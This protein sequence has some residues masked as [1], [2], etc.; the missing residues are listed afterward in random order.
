MHNTE[1]RINNINA[2]SQVS[3]T[4]AKLAR[5]KEDNIQQNTPPSFPPVPPDKPLIHR[6]LTEVCNKQAENVISERGCAVCGHLTPANNLSKLKNIKKF[7]HILDVRGVTRKERRSEAEPI[8]EISGPVL[9]YT[10]S[11]VCQVC[12][13]S[14]YKNKIPKLALA[15]GFWLGNVP[16]EL[17]EL[18]YVEKL[19]VARIRHTA[20][21]IKI[22]TGGRKMKAHATAFEIPTPKIYNLQDNVVLQ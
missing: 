16:K 14:L 8:T 13:K 11:E 2:T 9:D 18:R 19:L 22:S 15:K 3:T 5:S 1:G 10:C 12:R 21:F 20:C 6:I 17:A 7:L 4:S